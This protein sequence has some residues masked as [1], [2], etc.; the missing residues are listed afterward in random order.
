L[1]LKI[2]NRNTTKEGVEDSPPNS[3][4]DM[5]PCLIYYGQWESCYLLDL[6]R[7]KKIRYCGLAGDFFDGRGGSIYAR[8]ADFWRK[9]RLNALA[10]II[11]SA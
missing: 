6:R 1:Q 7:G 5:M 2:K 9:A 3:L 11:T 10:L 4:S 8:L